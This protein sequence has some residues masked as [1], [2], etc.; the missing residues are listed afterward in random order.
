MLNYENL[1]EQEIDNLS[2]EEM[3][4]LYEFV[5]ADIKSISSNLFLDYNIM[6]VQLID[7][8]DDHLDLINLHCSLSYKAKCNFT[9]ALGTVKIWDVLIYNHLKEKNVMIPPNVSHEFTPFAGAYVKNPVKKMYDW[10]VSIDLNSLYPHLIQQ[11]NISPECLIDGKCIDGMAHEKKLDDRFLNQVFSIDP[12]ATMAANGQYFRKDKRGFLP[13]IMEDL[14]AE[15]KEI[16]RDMLKEKQK[17]ID[18]Q[19]E[20]RKRGIK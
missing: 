10:V 5:D 12:R 3:T 7:L 9:D 14:Y 6:D 17:L 2:N 11:Y 13:Q 20:V 19:E 15:R 4:K 16:K 18:I 8:L 1:T